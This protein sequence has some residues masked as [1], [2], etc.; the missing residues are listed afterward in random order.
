M[1]NGEDSTDLIQDVGGFNMSY[2][3]YDHIFWNEN[4]LMRMNYECL[5]IV[6]DIWLWY[7]MQCIDIDD[8]HV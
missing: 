5:W 2:E 7:R 8:S 4:L 6:Y 1:G 3:S